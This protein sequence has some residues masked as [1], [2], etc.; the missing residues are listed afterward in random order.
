ME[1]Q[2][3]VVEGRTCVECPYHKYLID[4]ES[5]DGLYWDLDRVLQSKGKRQRVFEAWVD[6]DSGQVMVCPEEKTGFG[7]YEW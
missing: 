4:V 1:G 3:R 2:L 7:D 6:A 5:G